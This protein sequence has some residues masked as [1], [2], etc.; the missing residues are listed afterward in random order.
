VHTPSQDS[1]AGS[2]PRCAQ[3]QFAETVCVLE[4]LGTRR[5]GFPRQNLKIHGAWKDSFLYAILE[6]EWRSLV[7]QRVHGI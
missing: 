1:P 2:S 4:K 6:D 5:E 3:L 7:A